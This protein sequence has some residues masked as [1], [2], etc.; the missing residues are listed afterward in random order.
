MRLERIVITVVALFMLTYG[1][2]AR[3]PNFPGANTP[4]KFYQHHTPSVFDD[5]VQERHERVSDEKP[6]RY[7]PN[8]KGDCREHDDMDVLVYA[9][10]GFVVLISLTMLIGAFHQGRR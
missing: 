6:S 3:I 4:Q 1:V 7:S 5:P 2:Y 8:Y 9:F 10:L